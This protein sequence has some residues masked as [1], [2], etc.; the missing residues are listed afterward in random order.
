VVI[1]YGALLFDSINSYM[2]FTGSAQNSS[3]G[4]NRFITSPQS[5][6]PHGTDLI[7]TTNVYV[8]RSYLLYYLSGFLTLEQL[9]AEYMVH[10]APS[11]SALPLLRPDSPWVR[12]IRTGMWHCWAEYVTIYSH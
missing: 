6:L 9:V 11:P 12:L 7:R 3:D 2:S 1:I 10:K 5:L 8:D 4:S